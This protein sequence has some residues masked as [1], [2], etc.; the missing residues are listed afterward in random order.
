MIQ[1]V[2]TGKPKSDI[3]PKAAS[4]LSGTRAT[5]FYGQKYPGGLP[6]PT[7]TLILDSAAIQQQVRTLSHN[8]L[9]LRALIERNTDTVVAQGLNLAP[10]PKH[11]I[12]G[13]D[14]QAAEEW[15]SDV[16]TRFELWA[17]SP[18]SSRSAKYNFFQ[19]QRLMQKSIYR[20]GELFVALSY[21]NDPSLLSPLRFE[22]LDPSQIREN[23]YTY[24]A[25]GAGLNSLNKEGIIRNADGE[26]TAYKVW[27][28][29]AN[30]I[31]R[32]T[33]IPR[34][35]R[36]GRIM[37]LHALTGIDYAGQLRGISPLAICVNDLEA[38][39]DYTLAEVNKTINQSNI[40]FTV[41]SETDEPADDPF[42]NLTNA[43]A[44]PRKIDLMKAV[45]QYGANPNPD[46]NAQNVTEESIELVYD[47]AP[48][49]TNFNKPGG[50]GVFS[51]KGKQKLKPFQ[52]SAPSQNYNEF[53]K[54]YFSY[55]AAATGQSV[56][57][58]L[59]LFN[60]NYSASRATLILT[61][62]IAEQRRWEMDYYVLGPIYEMWLAEEIA[63]GRVSAP[64]WQ[65]PRLRAA[66]T[67]HRFNGLSMPNI[68]PT[69]TASAAKEYL[70]MG[71]TTLEDVAIEHNDSD[72]KS[73]RVKLKQE[74]E[75]LREIGAMPWG[76]SDRRV[77]DNR[78]SEEEE[79]RNDENNS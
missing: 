64:G 25:T 17:M 28:K 59:M 9:Q 3:K 5:R 79:N 15:G 75:E 50:I 27:T 10:E 49:H 30:G 32:M 66:W 63:A 39:L 69:K 73:N 2:L 7:P 20:D 13:I 42:K 8:S 37:M 54:A 38:I 74:L 44:G 36:S 48:P 57:T 16:K 77:S 78:D 60:N 70:S 40:A 6:Y 34:V 53:V 71:A 26:E 12:L 24:T 41:E 68:D 19:A 58:V 4:S 21:H 18:R 51:L 33:Q 35:G 22:L 11:Q 29:D 46:P 23:G 76:N 55:I 61:W 31:E 56:E 1:A 65:D 72:A 67:A 62:R 14:P 45:Q 52:N 47:E 43:G